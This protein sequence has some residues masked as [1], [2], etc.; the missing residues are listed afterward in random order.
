MLFFTTFEDGI[1]LAQKM[2]EKCGIKVTKFDEMSTSAIK[3][4]SNIMVGS[5]LSAIYEMLNISFIQGPPIF[6]YDMLGAIL[7]SLCSYAGMKSDYLLCINTK[8]VDQDDHLNMDLLFIPPEQT[9]QEV[10]KRL[11]L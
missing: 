6:I 7:D 11:H 3:E 10:L 5:Y 1:N 8:F 2:L 4:V 9:L